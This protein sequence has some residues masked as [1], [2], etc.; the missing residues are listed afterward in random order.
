AV[1]PTVTSPWSRLERARV[2]HTATLLNDG[3]LLVAGGQSSDGS[4]LAAAE[5][6][7]PA[8][9]GWAPAGQLSRT[10]AGHTATLLPTG[11]VLVAGGNDATAAL[12]TAEVYD[13]ASN[14]WTDVGSLA[15]GR[16]GH[17]ATV[18]NKDG[19]VLVAG[20]YY[21]ARR[22]GSIGYVVPGAAERYDP[23]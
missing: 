22:D 21:A 15:Q 5:L 16:E 17:T 13:P 10:R 3:R 1:R 9:N 8:A 23:V 19:R 20:G 12:A 14:A 4:Y 18:V 6:F 7:D 2:G 11:R